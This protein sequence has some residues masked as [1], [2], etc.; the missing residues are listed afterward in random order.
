MSK[1]TKDDLL[2]LIEDIA[3]NGSGDIRP[4]DQIKAVEFLLVNGGSG[5]GNVEEVWDE[6]FLVSEQKNEPAASE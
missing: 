5:E 4:A 1:L 3:E 6:L 2:G